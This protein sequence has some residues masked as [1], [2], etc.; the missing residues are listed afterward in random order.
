M[1]KIR[2]YNIAFT[3]L[4]NGKHDFIFNVKQEFFQLFDAE[5]EFDNANLEVNV[6]LDKHTTFLEFKVHVTGTVQLT[7]DISNEEFDHPIDNKI[8][9]LVKFGEEYDDSNEEVI[10]IPQQ[11]SDFNVAQIIFEAV[12]LAIPMKK[13]SPNLSEEDLELLD[14]FSP[15]ETEEEIQETAEEE[16]EKEVDP[17]WAALNK[18]KNKN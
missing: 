6:F 2:N 17:R 14:Q 4:K 16:E 10:T 13:L 12:V 18:L 5:Q 3:G 8:E 15:H 11:D 1:D 9:V 7:C